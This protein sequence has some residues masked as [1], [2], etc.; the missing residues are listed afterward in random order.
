MNQEAHE[1][2]ITV[3]MSQSVEDISEMY[4]K[5]RRMVE[6][7]AEASKLAEDLDGMQVSTTICL[8]KCSDGAGR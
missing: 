3:D 7:L 8:S 4:S 1:N 6:L 5:A 2:V